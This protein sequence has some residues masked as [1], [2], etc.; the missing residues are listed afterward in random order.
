LLTGTGMAFPWSV[1]QKVSLASGNIVE[2]IQLAVDLAIAGFSPLFCPDAQV[3]GV[4]PQHQHAANSQRKRWEHGYLQIMLT[5]I[6]V[7]LRASIAQKRFDLLAIALDLC[8]PPLSLLAMMWTAA[9]GGAALAAGL[10]ASWLPAIL[11]AMEG[12]LIPIS[13][14]AAWGKF[15]RANFPVQTMF[16]VPLYILWKIPLYLA[17]LVQP[18]TKWIRTQRDSVPK[19]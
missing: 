16:A 3:T 12:L 17:F 7:L 11:L 15:G 1:I 19:K 14:V 18:Q 5:Q 2:D 10:G 6:P 8:V 9:M 4:F 13:I